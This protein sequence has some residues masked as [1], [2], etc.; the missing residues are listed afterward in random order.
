M[1]KDD[2]A[3][4]HVIN[5]AKLTLVKKWCSGYD[6]PVTTFQKQS[7]ALGFR[8]D[9]SKMS[10]WTKT[11]DRQNPRLALLCFLFGR[12]NVLT[13]GTLI[14]DCV[15]LNTNRS[16]SCYL[17]ES[18]EIIRAIDTFVTAFQDTIHELP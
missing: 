17:E 14:H 4:P 7:Q 18:V 3:T 11:H 9:G 1:A 10:A 15:R 16:L 8:I 2:Y 12:R 6:N 5:K 13:Y